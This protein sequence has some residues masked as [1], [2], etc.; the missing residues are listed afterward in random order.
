MRLSVA[1]LAVMGLL[2]A[3]AG[4]VEQREYIRYDDFI[5]RVEAGSVRSVSFGRYG[6]IHG[7]I[8]TAKGDQSFATRVE[9]DTAPDTLL[10]RFL[11]AHQVT[12]GP[13]YEEQN[14]FLERWWLF[15]GFGFIV[16]ALGYAIPLATL[17]LII[18]IGRRLAR[19]EKVIASQSVVGGTVSNRGHR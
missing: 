15:I 17:W 11:T 7:S 16:S 4:A 5:A 10:T 2:V 9:H 14:P 19:L 18:R 1:I 8:R 13:H 6:E 3:R 12:I